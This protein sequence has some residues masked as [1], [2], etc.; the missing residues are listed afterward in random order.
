MLGDVRVRGGQVT[1]FDADLPTRLELAGRRLA[2]RTLVLSGPVPAGE[3]AALSER[4]N[5]ALPCTVSGAGGSRVSGS[6][7]PSLAH[8]I[9][10]S[11][12][13]RTPGDS[14]RVPSPVGAVSSHST[15]N[16][17]STCTVAALSDL[18]LGVYPEDPALVIVLPRF[19]PRASLDR[20]ADLGVTTGW[21]ILGVVGINRKPVRRWLPRSKANRPALALQPRPELLPVAAQA[22]DGAMSAQSSGREHD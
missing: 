3:L 5:D 19:A 8:Y 9:Q 22:G 14:R 2:A 7:L 13:Y 17:R 11:G 16:G 21:P 20:A 12:D 15:G 18:M 10:D 4:L 1:A 6:G